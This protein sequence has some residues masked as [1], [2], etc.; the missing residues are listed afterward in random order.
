MGE[1][2]PFE[3]PEPHRFERA[4]GKRSLFVLPR[5]YVLWINDSLIRSAKMCFL[6]IWGGWLDK[7]VCGRISSFPDSIG[8]S[9][10]TI[11]YGI[12]RR[13]GRTLMFAGSEFACLRWEENLTDLIQMEYF[14]R[15]IPACRRPSVEADVRLFE[16]G[17]HGHRNSGGMLRYSIFL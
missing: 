9:S 6:A 1:D 10:P 14:A 12:T 11:T 15:A 4:N 13:Y 5:P 7:E 16:M 2:I 3:F 8:I 17:W